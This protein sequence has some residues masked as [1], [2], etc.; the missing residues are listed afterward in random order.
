MASANNKG[1]DQSAHPCCLISAFV[2]RFLDSILHKVVISN[3]QLLWL[4][5]VAEQACLSVIGHT[6]WETVF[7]LT[8]PLLSSAS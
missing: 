7:L 4:P 1:A 5:S 3:I 2:F 8:W 6:N